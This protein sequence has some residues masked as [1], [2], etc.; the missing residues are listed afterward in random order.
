VL[1]ASVQLDEVQQIVDNVVDVQGVALWIADRKSQLVAAPG[2]RP[3]ALRPVAGAPIGAAVSA[4]PGRL[5]GLDVD[6]EDLLVVRQPVVP[7]G[8]TMYAAV[9]RDQ[10]YAGVTSIRNTVLATGVPLAGMVGAGIFLLLRTQ[11]RQ[12]RAD[13]EVAAARDQ[14]RDASRQKS[15]FLANMSHELRTP[16]NAILG[17]SE[18]MAQEPAHED[19][20]AA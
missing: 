13:A 12:W 7:L 20:R 4:A 6:G 15:E 8:W 19:T 10:A 14:A 18:L 11:R 1:A 3:A 16:L 17:F 9:P 5:V 2:G